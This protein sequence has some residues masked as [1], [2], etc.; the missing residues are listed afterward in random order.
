MLRPW[1]CLIL[2]AAL[3]WTPAQSAPGEQR[4]AEQTSPKDREPGKSEAMESGS[5]AARERDDARQRLWDRKMK[6]LAGSVCS[7]C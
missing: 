7:G 1:S 6:A 5:K 2:L 3:S 4:K